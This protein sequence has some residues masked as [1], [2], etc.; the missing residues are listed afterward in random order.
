MT[1]HNGVSKRTRGGAMPFRK[2]DV[3]SSTF[4]RSPSFA[5]FRGIAT[6]LRSMYPLTV[7]GGLCALALVVALGGARTVLDR[8][9]GAPEVKSRERPNGP[10]GAADPAESLARAFALGKSSER[11]VLVR[12]LLSAWAS[13]DAEA[14]L[15]WVSSLEDAAARRTARATVCLSLAEEDPRHAVTLALAHGADEDDDSGLLECLTMQWC[16]KESGAAL[17]WA[18]TQPRGEWQDRLVARASFVLSKSDPVR[19]GSLVSGLEPGVLQEEAAMAV[20]HQWALQDPSAALE[21]AEGFPEPALRERALAEIS[22][23]REMAASLQEA[24]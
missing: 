21:W 19:A 12:E 18:L 24:R 5:A 11:D 1:I 10:A 16:E 7:A 2:E 15:D 3:R 20:L 13:R 8:P 23:L 6:R 14:A 17:D 9:A 4:R 22:N